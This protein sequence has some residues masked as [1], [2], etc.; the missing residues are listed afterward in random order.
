VPTKE[1]MFRPLEIVMRMDPFD[2]LGMTKDTALAMLAALAKRRS[3]RCM[4]MI[5]ERT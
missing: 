5:N 1:Q 4:S 2:F 3:L